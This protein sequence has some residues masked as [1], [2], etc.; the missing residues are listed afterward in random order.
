MEDDEGVLDLAL[1]YREH[2]RLRERVLCRQ[3]SCHPAWSLLIELLIAQL[4]KET[5]SVST[6]T[7][8][9]G[10]RNTTALRWI[11]WLQGRRLIE[12]RPDP[13]NR[14]RAFITL[15]A[16]GCKVVKAMLVDMVANFDVLQRTVD[17]VGRHA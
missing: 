2:L 10:I 5:L 3:A 1:A 16:Q 12:R 4:R 17:P 6:L 15:S 9:A 11:D 13:Q 7:R 14:L 8:A